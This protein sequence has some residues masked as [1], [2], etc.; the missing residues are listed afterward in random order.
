[1]RRRLERVGATL[2][3]MGLLLSVAV[4]PVAAQE[5]ATS[6]ARA[7]FERGLERAN[8][9][10]WVEALEEFR[11]SLAILDRPATR[12]NVGAALLRLGRLVEARTEMDTLLAVGSLG[13]AERAQAT[14]IRE[15]AVQGIRTID[16]V[17][18][19][20]DATLLVDG[21]PRV[22]QQGRLDL[23]P[24]RHVIEA[25]ASG[26]VT[27]T[28]EVGADERAVILRLRV[29]PA[30][31]RVTSSVSSASITLDGESRGSGS[32][33]SDV[34]SGRHQL[35]VTAEGHE[36]FERWLEL[37]PAQELDVL[38]QLV[39]RGDDDLLESPWF[40]G[41]GGAIVVVAGVAIGL[42]VGLSSG[43][44]LDGG[45]VGDVLRP[46]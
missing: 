39:V 9:E 25:R 15:H 42:G 14:S 41:V 7:H 6:E 33:E 26:F 36:P 30:H 35:R 45:S 27:E 12:L 1:M 37:A 13:D 17:V 34:A 23:D 38:A 29:Q 31:L 11:L 19:P 40:W 2:L 28:R 16:V 22:A 21:A 43:G 32:F 20:T 4:A 10:A 18:E 24:G 3:A 46:R 44:A 8:A 5:G